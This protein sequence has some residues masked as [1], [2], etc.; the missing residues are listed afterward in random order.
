[1]KEAK[2]EEKKRAEMEYLQRTLQELYFN[3]EKQTAQ[4]RELTRNYHELG[5]KPHFQTFSFIYKFLIV[6]SVLESNVV[7]IPWSAKKSKSK[8]DGA[9]PSEPPSAAPPTLSGEPILTLEEL[10]TDTTEVSPNPPQNK[11]VMNNIL[12]SAADEIEKELFHRSENKP[13]KEGLVTQALN[14]IYKDVYR[15]TI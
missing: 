11:L 6:R 15:L 13:R 12:L 4:I 14:H 9:P 8:S 10:E 5:I 2:K 7:Q 1:M 3:M